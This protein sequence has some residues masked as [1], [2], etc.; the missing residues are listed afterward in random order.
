MTDLSDL[1]DLSDFIDL[2]DDLN[3]S[4]DWKKNEHILKMFFQSEDPAKRKGKSVYDYTHDEYER[5]LNEDTPG[6][7][8][9]TKIPVHINEMS[10]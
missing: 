3:Q 8:D 4:V 6:G 2:F 1:T 10:K 5:I 7:R 9:L